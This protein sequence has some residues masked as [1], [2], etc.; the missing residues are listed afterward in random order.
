[1]SLLAGTWDVTAA[2]EKFLARLGT[3]FFGT[4][5]VGGCKNWF[6]S[7]LLRPSDRVVAD[8][9]WFAARLV[10]HVD[11]HPAESTR[12]T[13]NGLCGGTSLSTFIRAL[14]SGAS[15][16]PVSRQEARMISGRTTLI[17]HIGYPT[18]TFKA[19]LIYNP[20]FGEGGD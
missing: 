3:A 8:R 14:A 19:P 16:H 12:G 15:A 4:V 9:L 10:D 6:T 18:E 11:G 20:Y 7:Q 1:M 5:W 13:H 2:T 17:A